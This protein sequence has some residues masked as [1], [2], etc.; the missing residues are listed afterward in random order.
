MSIDVLK[1]EITRFLASTEPEV[2]CINGKW[3]T[4]KTHA[5]NDLV[6]KSKEAFGLKQYG[7]ISLYGINSPEKL[8]LAILENTLPVEQIGEKIDPKTIW[9]NPVTNT[10]NRWRKPVAWLGSLAGMV[11][12][13]EVFERLSFLA[14]RNQIVCL[15]DLER[16]GD[17][18]KI[19]DVLGLATFLKEQRNC[20]VV[21][22][23]NEGAFEKTEKDDF[24][25]FFEKTV[26]THIK[27][28]PTAQE[29]ST[30][31]LPN[32]TRIHEELRN[33][34]VALGITNIRVIRRV[35]R[36]ARLL[37]PLLATYHPSVFS[38]FMK[39]LMLL[40]WSR[41]SEAAPKIEFLKNRRSQLYGKEE[42]GSPDE[43]LWGTILDEYGM[44][45]FSRTSEIVL[46]SIERGFFIP[47]LVN[48]EAQRLD[49]GYK[50]KQGD[51]DFHNAWRL[52][53]D[54]FDDNQ[55]EVI[56]GLND[57]FRK[58]A[59]YIRPLNA[60][61]TVTLF[62][63]LNQGSLADELVQLYV[64]S[65]GPEVFDVRNLF[66]PDDIS[67][68]GF[69]KAVTKKQAEVKDSR[70]PKQV[71]LT[72]AQNR[73]WSDE[74]IALLSAMSEDS[75]LRL[76]KDLKNGSELSACIR[77]ALS[78]KT[79]GGAGE[80]ET[81]IADKTKAALIKIGNESLLNRR[82]V[83]KYGINLDSRDDTRVSN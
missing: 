73:S 83:K 44:Q 16:K 43:E 53:H 26:D 77:M 66:L 61:S 29:C 72:I 32:D 25:Q 28:E 23:L 4:G 59:K 5:W 48:E 52:F 80:L 11:D 51:D 78:F 34:V 65:H 18:L 15:D 71:L 76:F 54:G 47:D 74:D 30:I 21:L 13:S 3:G 46:E 67:D 38:N 55:D 82:R 40:G 36:M 49:S 63:D 7:F 69:K 24:L 14:V 6:L 12:L 22:I 75:Y 79:M 20:K 27:F 70:D 56:T 42:D 39:E 35:E 19:K 50:E 8:K 2:L 17:D 81:S 68:E 33:H 37:E 58:N 64:D 62:R 60:N 10:K 1:N 57:S 31:A 45:Y 41:Y 9:S